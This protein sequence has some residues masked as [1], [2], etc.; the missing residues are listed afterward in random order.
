MLEE[1][2]CRVFTTSLGASRRK[3]ALPQT[4]TGASLLARLRAKRAPGPVYRVLVLV[5]FGQL[6]GPQGIR[7]LGGNVLALFLHRLY[8]PIQSFTIRYA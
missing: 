6:R 5:W 2:P 3:C 7:G 8:Q 1:P 4:R